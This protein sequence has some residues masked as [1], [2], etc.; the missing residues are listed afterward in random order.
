MLPNHPRSDRQLRLDILRLVVPLAS[1]K[2]IDSDE[3]V[4]LADDLVEW[5][6]ADDGDDE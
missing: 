3:I 1:S 4:P 5:V 2:A 6:S